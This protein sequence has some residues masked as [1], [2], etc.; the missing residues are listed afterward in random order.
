MINIRPGRITNNGTD[1]QTSMLSDVYVC[2]YM[3]LHLLHFTE[4]T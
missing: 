3:V 1:V 4:K 2:F